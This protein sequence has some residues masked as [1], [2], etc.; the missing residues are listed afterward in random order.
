M[1]RSRTRAYQRHGLIIVA[2]EIK[3]EEVIAILRLLGDGSKELTKLLH[4]SPDEFFELYNASSG[5]LRIYHK[6]LKGPKS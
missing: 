2:G 5:M 1:V 4:D 3:L 6:I